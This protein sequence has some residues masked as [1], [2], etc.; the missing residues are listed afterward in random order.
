MSEHIDRQRTHC[1][2]ILS[3]NILAQLCRSASLG[4]ELLES[5]FQLL[6]VVWVQLHVNRFGYGVVTIDLLLLNKLLNRINMFCLE[7]CNF[8]CCVKTI[9]C[10]ES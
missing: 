10:G 5:F 2:C 1:F 3:I 9:F 8:S 6:I 4:H 7:V